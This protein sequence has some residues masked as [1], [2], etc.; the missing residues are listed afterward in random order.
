M[1]IYKTFETEGGSTKVLEKLEEMK[2]HKNED[3]KQNSAI[4]G[5]LEKQ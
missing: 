5:N 1:V 3:S 2:A 4:P